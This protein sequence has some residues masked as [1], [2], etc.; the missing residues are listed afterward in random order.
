MARSFNG[1]SDNI[2]AD[3]AAIWNAN[4]AYSAAMWLNGPQQSATPSE[5]EFFAEAVSSGHN[6]VFAL[7]NGTLGSSKKAAI[8]SRNAAGVGLIATT[9]TTADVLDSTWHHLGYTQDA[10]GNWQL[11]VDGATDISGSF[12]PTTTSPN[13]FTMGCLRWNGTL[14]F[15]NGSMAHVAKW[16]RQLSAKEMAS[17]ATGM[18]PSHLAPDHYWPLW[19]VDSPEPD[20]GIA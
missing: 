11:Y 7:R 8:I 20:L 12:S 10:S 17:L 13:L 14:D 9:N 15:F 4:A 3:A 1:T 2:A 19:G 6:P 18:L 5:R 16:S